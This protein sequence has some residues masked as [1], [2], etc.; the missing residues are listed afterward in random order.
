MLTN[1]SQIIQRNDS[2]IADQR[3]LLLNHEADHLGRELSA[4][5]HV[6]ALALD[7][8]HHLQLQPFA[9]DKLTLHF[10]HQLPTQTKFDTVVI[11]FPKA[12]PLAEYLFS[13]AAQYLDV[14]GQVLI[15]GENKGGIK[16]FSKQFPKYFSTPVKIDNARHCLLFASELIAPAPKFDLND[17]VT[18]YSLPTPQGEINI[19][20]CVGV[21]SQ[22]QLDA[23]TKL[24]LENLAEFSGRVLDFG[25]GAGVISAALLKVQPELEIDCVDINAMALASCELTLQANNLQAKVYAS[26]GYA[27]IQGEFNGVISNPPF[28][29]GLAATTDI[30]QQFVKESAHSLFKHG[31]FQIVANRHLPYAD[32]IDQHFGTVNVVAE[33]NKY[34]VYQNRVK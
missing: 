22:K 4:A 9:N 31:V 21:F 30:A 3:V 24:L 13:L 17:W 25:C 26:D 19:C 14:G 8:N 27:Q 11:Y 20:N 29:D 7:F 18:T 1:P 34:K 33:N 6:T 5:T 10:S 12:K 32:D 2:L 16:S 23:G 15:V 28:H